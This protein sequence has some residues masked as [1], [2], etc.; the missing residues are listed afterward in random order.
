MRERVRRERPRPWT[1]HRLTLRP[2]WALP[3][4]KVEWWLAWTSWALGHWALLEVLEH[5]GTLSVLVAVIF[6]FS[7]RGDRT[8]QRHYQAWQVINTAQGQGG[9][10]G[11]IEALQELN[12]DGVSLIGLKAGE[13]FLQGARLPGAQLS[14]CDLHAT[15]LRG[16]NLRK[17]KLDF[18]NL[19]SANLR[20]GNLAGADLSDAA[21][22]DADLGEANL[23][24]AK[25]A[26]ADLSRVD[27]R[28]ADGREM[29][30]RAI[31]SIKL[32]NVY[33]MKNAPAGFLEFALKQGAVSVESD[34]DW[35]GLLRA[36]ASDGK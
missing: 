1:E 4:Y 8:K 9:S 34:D 20:G 18:C 30:W 28:W 26:H 17:A 31:D 6:Y 25:L 23:A 35:N 2:Q 32:A 19:R 15:D 5:L 16:A 21:L 14:R 36:A 10:G 33:G 24:G 22:E 27:L 13:A 7:E 11:R 12:A 3:F 29:D